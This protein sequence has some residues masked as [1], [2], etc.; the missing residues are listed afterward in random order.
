M[1]NQSHYRENKL[2][3]FKGTWNQNNPLPTI[4]FIYCKFRIFEEIT[5]FSFNCVES[6]VMLGNNIV[7]VAIFVFY[8]F[9]GVVSQ[10]NYNMLIHSAYLLLNV[11]QNVLRLITTVFPPI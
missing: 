10:H 7:N 5:N 8:S 11:A 9:T 1:T 2:S 3:H 6:I 4:R